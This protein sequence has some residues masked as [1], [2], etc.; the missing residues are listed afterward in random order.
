[1]EGTMIR[2][3]LLACLALAAILLFQSDLSA[4]GYQAQISTRLA[5]DDSG[6]AQTAPDSSTSDNGSSG[7]S[8][9]P[10]RDQD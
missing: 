7:D 10:A 2:L 3:L 8:G 4:T 6:N 9:K 1:M 5:Q